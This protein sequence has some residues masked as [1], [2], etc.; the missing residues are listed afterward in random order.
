MISIH[1]TNQSNNQI[2]ESKDENKKDKLDIS[3]FSKNIKCLSEQIKVL[4]EDNLKC[5]AFIE[6]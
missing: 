2:V 6:K 5:N 3:I 1:K 4:T